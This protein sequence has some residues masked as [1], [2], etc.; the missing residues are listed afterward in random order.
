MG[1]SV[2]DPFSAILQVDVLRWHNLQMSRGWT[3]HLCRVQSTDVE[4]RRVYPSLGSV[5]PDPV[6][7][8]TALWRMGPMLVRLMTRRRM[9]YDAQIVNHQSE[10]RANKPAGGAGADG[11]PVR[12]L[13]KWLSDSFE[14]YN[15]VCS[16]GTV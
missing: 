3:P 1:N 9:I 15:C 14:F 8:F 6:E 11:Q 4:A 13:L 10:L 12:P 2:A 16:D 7:D 5:F